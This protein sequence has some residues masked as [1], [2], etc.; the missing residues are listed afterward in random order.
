MLQKKEDGLKRIIMLFTSKKK[1]ESFL[2]VPII[3]VKFNKHEGSLRT[4]FLN[5]CFKL[6]LFYKIIRLI[7]ASII[8][9]INRD[10][11]KLFLFIK[12]FSKSQ[13][14]YLM[15]EVLSSRTVR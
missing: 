2:L 1:F 7:N 14:N 15:K 10:T 11:L 12:E 3:C 4:I 13:K 8:N 5:F 6:K 9:F